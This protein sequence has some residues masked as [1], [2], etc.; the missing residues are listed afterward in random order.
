MMIIRFDIQKGERIAIT[1]TTKSC[2]YLDIQEDGLV[3]V[4]KIHMLWQSLQQ[5][6]FTWIHRF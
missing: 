1:D 2:T 6:S 4:N 5:S 3:T